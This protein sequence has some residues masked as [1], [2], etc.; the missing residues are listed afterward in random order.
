MKSL[1]VKCNNHLTLNMILGGLVNIGVPKVYLE[2]EIAKTPWPVKLLVK[3]NSK[4]QIGTHY[5]DIEPIGWN[6]IITFSSMREFWNRLCK[7]THPEFLKMGLEVIKTLEN[8]YVSVV[9]NNETLE[10]LHITIESLIS[11]YLLFLSMQY[12]EIEVVFTSPVDIDKG[13]SLIGELTSYILKRQGSTV[14]IPISPEEIHPFAAAVLESLS[15]DFV[16]VDGRFIIDATAY[17]SDSIEN[18]TGENTVTLYM[19]YYTDKTS[20]VFQKYVQIF[21]L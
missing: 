13:K 9:K 10:S 17:G 11:L 7:S 4:V 6:E 2:S 1:I 21:G 14:G 18:P 8:G 12:L 19:G 16:P 5:F 15:K 20:S 3:S